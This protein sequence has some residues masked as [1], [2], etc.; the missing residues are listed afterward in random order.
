MNGVA[1]IL[2]DNF[3]YAQSLTKTLQNA[4]KLKMGQKF[5]CIQ[6]KI[7]NFME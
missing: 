4:T 2:G 3:F 1:L 6:L 7:Q 5:F